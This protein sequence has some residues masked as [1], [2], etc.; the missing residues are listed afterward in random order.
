MTTLCRTC[1]QEAEHARTLFDKEGSDV[2][3]NILRL[4][5]ILLS[6]E[7]G[8][9]TMICLSCL[10]DLNEAIAFRERCIKTNNSW[11]QDQDQEE[12]LGALT[13]EVIGPEEPFPV[14]GKIPPKRSRTP[15]EIQYKAIDAPT[16]PRDVPSAIFVDPLNCDYIIHVKN[17]PMV[18]DEE[19]E[20]SGNQEIIEELPG[21]QDAVEEKS[22][23]HESLE[24]QPSPERTKRGRTSKTRQAKSKECSKDKPNEKNVDYLPVKRKKTKEEKYATRNKWAAE[25]R[26]IAKEK[27]LYFCDQCGKTFSE[28]G[29]FN[30]HLTRHKGTKEFQCKECDRREFTQ[31]LLNLHVRVKHRGELPYV[32][33]FCGQRFDNCLK[34]LFHERKHEEDPN[35]RPYV[36]SICNKGFKKKE[37]LKNHG[38]T[39][40]GEQPF[41]CELCQAHFNRR[42]SLA[43][44]FKSKQHQKKVLE[45]A[46]VQGGGGKTELKEE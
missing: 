7:P 8:V 13:E 20:E 22:R 3:H 46:K 1:G 12:D 38:V 14:L 37:V 35:H 32:C 41:H 24:E 6:N 10:L 18:S 28:K 19:P 36:C 25:K 21:N 31:H 17:E 9:P 5:G 43:T 45:Q 42:N 15:E 40:T 44:H 26:A 30:V 39:H 4:T 27:K 33:K 16:T 11:F 34:R 23:N 29:N 2:L